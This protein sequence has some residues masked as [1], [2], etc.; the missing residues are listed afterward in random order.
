M[1]QELKIGIHT[2]AFKDAE[3][4][5]AVDR[6]SQ[7][8]ARCIEF[9][10]G[11]LD[12]YEDPARAVSL[13]LECR[14]R[15]LQVLSNDPLPIENNPLAARVIFDQ[16]REFDLDVLNVT[17]T[18]DVI[19]LLEGLALEY[20]QKVAICNQGPETPWSSIGEIDKQLRNRDWRVGLCMDT[21][22]F[23]RVP[24]DPVKVMEI[25]GNRVHSIHLRDIEA[26]EEG[27]IGLEHALGEGVLDVPRLVGYLEEMHFSGPIILCYQGLDHAPEDALALGM[28]RL[29]MLVRAA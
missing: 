27:D 14:H 26:D 1:W 12:F 15:G 25:F 9:W 16:A 7:L 29:G 24:E 3:V 21:G 17:A 19:P 22:L 2:A 6:V 23:L 8:G 11:H 28:E 4:Y 18:A 5:E 13:L 10:N 20:G